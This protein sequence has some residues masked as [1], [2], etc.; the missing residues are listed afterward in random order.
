MLFTA[1]APTNIPGR[2][3]R[4]RSREFPAME[5]CGKGQPAQPDP[6][7]SVSGLEPCACPREG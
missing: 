2:A 3:R 4:Q 1:P 7:V 6:P 5:D